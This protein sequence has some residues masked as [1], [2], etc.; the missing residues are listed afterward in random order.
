[1]EPKSLLCIFLGYSNQYK[2]YYYLYS[3]TMK[4][5]ISWH[6]VFN[7]LNFPY[8]NLEDLYLASSLANDFSTFED[9]EDGG[10]VQPP[11]QV[12]N[13]IQI[14]LPSI[15]AHIDGATHLTIASNY[16]PA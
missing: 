7:E 6:F 10:I 14:M 11:P 9:W 16:R 3:G 2:G 12:S 4:I 15:N 5:Y 13:D 8:K 1:M